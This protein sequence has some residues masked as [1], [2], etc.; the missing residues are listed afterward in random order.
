[1]LRAAALLALALAAMVLPVFRLPIPTGPYAV[2]PVILDG[3][4]IWYPAAPGS[5]GRRAPYGPDSGGIARRILRHAR[6]AALLGAPAAP[7]PFPVI[8][9]CNGWGGTAW[10]NTALLQTLASHGYVAAAANQ[11]TAPIGGVSITA[12]MDLSSPAAWAA[13]QRIAA[14]KLHAQTQA[15]SDLLARLAAL[16]TTPN[17]PLTAR[18]DLTKIGAL[19]FSFGG[20]TAAELAATD[21]RIRAAVNMDGLHFGA[22]RTQG[23]RVPYLEFSD[24]EP[25]TAPAGAN[26]ALT[27]LRTIQ[28]DDDRTTRAN[29]ARNG[30]TLL[31]ITGTLHSNFTDDPLLIPWRRFTGAGP[32][33]PH[34]AARIIAAWTTAFFDHAFRGAPL[35]NPAATPEIRLDHWPGPAA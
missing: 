30:G 13:T 1:M 22:A 9:Y 14:L 20:A 11:P 23:V 19:G 15:A 33:D 8:L 29:F 32:I 24:D 17:T 26:Q 18:L 21:P 35:P 12:P 2:G 16:N 5:T 27:T 34:C 4:Q 7:G 6:T 3:V 10:E 31:T 28:T 25:L